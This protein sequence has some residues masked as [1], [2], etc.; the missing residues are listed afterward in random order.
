MNYREIDMHTYAIEWT[1]TSITWILDG[2]MIYQFTGTAA[3]PIPSESAKI[4]MNLW[5]FGTPAA[6]GDPTKNVYPFASEYEYFRFYKWDQEKTYPCSPTPSCL[7]MT[8]TVFSR[9][10]PN[11]T[12]YPN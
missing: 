9:N 6:F 5:V 1:P 12:N 8:D 2:A 10:N 7:P 4:M 11:E 3:V